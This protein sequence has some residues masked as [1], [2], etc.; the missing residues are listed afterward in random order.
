MQHLN[1]KLEGTTNLAVAAALW[2]GLA[3]TA[4]EVH[5]EALGCGLNAD[6]ADAGVF[7]VKS[8]EAAYFFKGPDVFVAQDDT[9]Q[10]VAPNGGSYICA[11]V[12]AL[13][14]VADDFATY[15][16]RGATRLCVNA[17]ESGPGAQLS[18]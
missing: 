1:P 16:N 5:A 8:V 12:S 11:D 14:H 18:N 17:A 2:V 10:I 13:S 3:L 15:V 9:V 4:T 7:S 6:C